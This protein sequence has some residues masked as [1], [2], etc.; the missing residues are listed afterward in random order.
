MSDGGARHRFAGRRVL[1]TG[2]TGFKGSWLSLWLV[3]LGAEVSGFSDA[4]PTDPSHF[5]ALKLDLDDRRGDICNPAAIDSAMAEARPEIVFHLAAQSLVRKAYSDP[6]TTYRANV[7]GTLAVLEAARRNGVGVV[8]V[9]TTDKVYRNDDSGR[10]FGEEDELGG[11]DPYSASKACVELLARSCRDSFGGSIATVR[12]GNVIGGGDWAE[13]RLLPDLMRAAFSGEPA[14][15]RNPESTRPWQHV[16][17]VLAGY[18]EI[19]ARLIDGGEGAEA[20]NL[21]PGSD[22]AIRVQDLIDSV[23][24]Q[25]PQLR[26]EV[27]PDP[28]GGR[29]A[30]LL[31][32]DSSKAARRLGWRPRW[33]GEMIERTIDWYRAYYERGRVISAEQLDAYEAAL[34]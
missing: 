9:A 1:V 28:G 32:L 12:A 17:D 13:D 19:G 24:Q 22:A 14:V 16:L 25:V 21:G 30:A 29:E 6:L 8:V 18:L 4:I 23:R 11:S 26:V 20:W 2:H 10:R 34:A 31:Q 33:E 15:I 27:R 7:M 3:R 5:A